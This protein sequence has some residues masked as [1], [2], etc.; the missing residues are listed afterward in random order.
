VSQ[1]LVNVNHYSIKRQLRGLRRFGSYVIFHYPL[2][3]LICD[4]P[5]AVRMLDLVVMNQKAHFYNAKGKQ[6]DK[7]VY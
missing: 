6:L 4:Y 3:T 1:Y 7:S 5:F 2:F